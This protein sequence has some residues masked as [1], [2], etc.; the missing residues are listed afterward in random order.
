MSP[1]QRW[2]LVL[3]G[4]PG[5]MVSLDILC[6]TTALP[7][8]RAELGS[9]VTE[10]EWSVTAYN[11]SFA[12]ALLPFSAFGDRL[13]RRRSFAAGVGL[14]TAGSLGCAL[15]GSPGFLIG[16]RAVQGLG[17]AAIVPIGM[18]LVASAFPVERRGRA[19]GVAA[20]A[21]GLATLSGPVVGGMVTQYLGWQAI[22]W[23]NVPLGLVAIPLILTR[24]KE[25][26][27]DTARVDLIGL[28]LIAAIVLGTVTATSPGTP[29]RWV[30]VLGCGAGAA[31]AG[32][33]R[34]ERH[35]S[36]PIIPPEF[37]RLRSVVTGN[38]ASLLH[39]AV[40]L[41]SVFWMAQLFH[42][43]LGYTTVGTGL[44]LL[45][46]T[47]TFPVVAPVAGRLV[48]RIGAHPV[49]VAS[50]LLQAG[51]LIW[52]TLIL[53]PDVS[54]AALFTPL[55]LT[56]IGGSA[57]FPAAAT[58]VLTG[59]A[60]HAIG[61]ASGLTAV[62]R[63]YGGVLGITVVSSAFAHTGGYHTATEILDGI[64]TVLILCAAFA[65]TAAL[66]GASP[67]LRHRPEPRGAADPD[68]ADRRLHQTRHSSSPSVC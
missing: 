56:G 17:A 27:A 51:G 25:S 8:I 34:W 59:V 43:G 14:F 28:G 63:E 68:P 44:A 48:D 23:V 58:A 67:R 6:L 29:G 5:L 35:A 64:R 3:T 45:P 66:I 54:Y 47:G 53:T 26:A 57:A 55:L 61:R 33:V 15:A 38:A 9:S 13:G 46:W 1:R 4:V 65:L 40:V 62:L 11:L 2:V 41:G 32:L 16:A 30:P 12:L 21:T 50:L 19:L 42:D 24:I 20:I 36:D 7:V 31:L 60:D 39:S 10:L 52:V 49:L 22:F 37:L 18:A